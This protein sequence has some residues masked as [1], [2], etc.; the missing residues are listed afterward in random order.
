M[1]RLSLTSNHI[2]SLIFAMKAPKHRN[3]GIS[4]SCY[5]LAQIQWLRHCDFQRSLGLTHSHLKS[6]SQQGA[7]KIPVLNQR[8]ASVITQINSPTEAILIPGVNGVRE[9]RLWMIWLKLHNL[10]TEQWKHKPEM[11]KHT[12]TPTHTNSQNELLSSL[13]LSMVPSGCICR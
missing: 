9:T 8:V 4:Q 3:T 1:R 10:S 2:S 13:V 5:S 12:H 7:L 11:T 6:A